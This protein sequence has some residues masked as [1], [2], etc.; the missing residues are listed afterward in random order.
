VNV[1]GVDP[2]EALSLCAEI[3]IAITGFS[4]VVLVFDRRVGN[5]SAELRRV[6]FRT[7]ITATLVPLGLI[8]VAFVLEAGGIQRPAIWRICSS[9]HVVA[10][11]SIT[12]INALASGAEVAGEVRSR[13]V[14]RPG[15]G[16]LAGIM[17]AGVVTVV[18]LQVANAVHFHAFW[19]VLTAIWWGIGVSLVAF[20]SL[21]F[22]P[23]SSE[24]A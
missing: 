22:I 15:W 9:V 24:E 16:A 6:T 20:A 8:G 23:G 18:G 7:L 17:L 11:T 1:V 3:A 13:F 21:V 10:V 14:R 2:F 12:L 4:G 5:A 19:P